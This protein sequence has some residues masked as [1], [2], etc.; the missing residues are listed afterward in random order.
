MPDDSRTAQLPSPPAIVCSGA[1]RQ[2]DPTIFKGTG[3]Q[4]A[5]DW[6]TS[7][8]RVSAYNR[9]DDAMKRY[10]VGFCF[11]EVAERWFNNNDAKMS[12]WDAF[13]ND[14]MDVFGRPALRKLLAQQRLGERAQQAGETFTS[15]IEDII[16]LCRRAND[17]MPESEKIR[18]IM[19]GIEEDAFQMLLSK[20]PQNIGEVVSLCQSYDE[21][22]KQRI[23]ARHRLA[24]TDASLSALSF[25]DPSVQERIKGLVRE[26][27][28]RQLSL[29][30]CTV[31]T[32][33]AQVPGVASPLHQI[34]REQVAEALPSTCQQTTV[35]A[36]L[37]YA[38][39][40]SAPR[41]P[42]S[43]VPYPLSTP[44]V[45][46]GVIA[47]PRYTGPPLVRST[48]TPAR[49]PLRVSASASP[50]PWRTADNRP[51]CFACRIPG[52]VARFC[53]RVQS[54]D[55]AYRGHAYDGHPYMTRQPYEPTSPGQPRRSFA[56]DE[57]SRHRSPSPRRRS[58]SPMHRRPSAPHEEN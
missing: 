56:S 1:I 3:D 24:A 41:H 31:P 22:R 6:L 44:I 29:L 36:P 9:W 33:C 2:R 53:R 52:H 28:A 50:N 21:L 25:D 46:D 10:N 37:S 26:E 34:I 14:F 58:L 16:D 51:I 55:Y 17:A 7:Y 35:T 42:G 32:A 39:V 38:D 54:S 8:E 11:R 23:Y 27:V 30:S 12:T 45:Y 18:H 48:P 57:P 15:Y 19:K 20:N 4:D 13:K 5:E 47:R 43:S 40:A 49:P